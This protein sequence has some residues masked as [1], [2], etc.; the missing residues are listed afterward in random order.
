MLTGVSVTVALADLVE[1]AWL[2]TV[3]VTTCCE[4]SEAGAVY[5]PFVSEP[6]A[7]DKDH[8]TAVLLDPA[9]FQPN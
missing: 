8:F 6:T 4:A 5:F 7:G 1:S 3:I 2:V 9:T